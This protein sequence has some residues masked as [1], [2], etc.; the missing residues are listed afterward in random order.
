MSIV[1]SLIIYRW[2]N[3][4][5]FVDIYYHLSVMEM[6]NQAGGVVVHDFLQYAPFGRD[7]LY[8]PLLHILIL[9]MYKLGLSIDA[10]GR[11]VSAGMFPLTM[12]ASWLLVRKMFGKAEAFLT[13]ALLLCSWQYFYTT[14]IVSASALATVLALF[15][16]NLIYLER[17]KAAI[18]IMAFCLYTHMSYPHLITFSLI[19]WAV[20]SKERRPAILRVVLFSYILFSPWLFLIL[21]NLGSITSTSALGGNMTFNA[22]LI[23]C[24]IIGAS[25]AIYRYLGGEKKY[26]LPLAMLMSMVPAI[27]YYKSRFFV[28]STV[29]MAILGALGMAFLIEKLAFRLRKGSS[30]V[31]IGGIL[32]VT[33]LF[34]TQGVVYSYNSIGKHDEAIPDSLNTIYEQPLNLYNLPQVV[35]D[36]YKKYGYL[37]PRPGQNNDFPPYNPGDSRKDN[38][39][40]DNDGLDLEETTLG[41][42][43]S[44]KTLQTP[45]YM[46]PNVSNLLDNISKNTSPDDII[47]VE[48]GIN[49]CIVTAYTGRATTSGM[50]HEVATD[51]ETSLR[52]V[53]LEM[54]GTVQEKEGYVVIERNGLIEVP[55]AFNCY[56]VFLLVIIGIIVIVVDIINKGVSDEKGPK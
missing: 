49:G 17:T 39:P 13:L 53:I 23:I 15:T 45:S 5:F 40:I 34:L 22:I 51:Y 25:F 38:R 44:G 24:S 9:G 20:L 41:A 52:Q 10:I 1:L 37:P 43:I 3:F 47:L 56:I 42:L 27:F 48:R 4:P 18:V 19:I 32:L 46:L 16:Y 54:G 2:E 28:H 8:P 31:Y 11:I 14:A 29:P 30:A 33:T 12:M 26:I 36:F 7:H 50:F 35:Q 55:K 6:F 21:V